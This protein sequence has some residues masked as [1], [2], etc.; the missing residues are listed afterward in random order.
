MESKPKAAGQ[1]LTIGSRVARRQFLVWS[2][3]GSAAALLAACAPSSPPAPT[4]APAP[5]APKSTESAA[6]PAA[7]VAAATQAPAAKPAQSAAAGVPAEWTVA[8]P[9]DPASLDPTVDFIT[10]T[11]LQQSLIFDP[12]V[13]F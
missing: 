2:V 7:P 5:A 6:Q 8:L 11:Q 9:A 1:E 10:I 13:D 12:L 3:L 4:N